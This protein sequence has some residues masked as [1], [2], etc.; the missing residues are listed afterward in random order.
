MG[1]GCE[2]CMKILGSVGCRQRANEAHLKWVCQHRWGADREQ[3][4]LIQ[5]SEWKMEYKG[6]KG[7]REGG[8]HSP[9]WEVAHS[10][11][12]NDEDRRQR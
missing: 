1:L 2:V 7:E 11:E 4:R 6:G 5:G 3:A 9:T 8:G 12:S 10:Y